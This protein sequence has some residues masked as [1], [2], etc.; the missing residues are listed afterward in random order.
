MKCQCCGISDRVKR[1]ELVNGSTMD[2]CPPCRRRHD[3]M[4]V[5]VPVIDAEDARAEEANAL[6]TWDDGPTLL[7]HEYGPADGAPYHSVAVQP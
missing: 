6:G 1:C 5:S 7:G 2:L 4:I 3:E